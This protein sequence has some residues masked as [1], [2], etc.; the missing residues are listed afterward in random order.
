LKHLALLVV[1][2]VAVITIAILTIDGYISLD[3]SLILTVV[4]VTLGVL[5]L[6]VPNFID[7]FL[8][9][10]VTLQVENL[11]FVRKKYH[12]V[13]GY[14]LKGLIT[15]KGKR[16][17]LNLDGAFKIE[18]AQHRSP[19]LLYLRFDRE[20]G[21]ERVEAREEPMRAV[22]YAWI[23]EKDRIYRGMWKESRQK[24]CV[25]FVFP[26]ETVHIGVG[27]RSFWSEY[28]LKLENTKYQVAVEAKGED[29]EKNTVIISK[30]TKI[31][32]TY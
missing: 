24:D 19:N 32:P 26:Y 12:D 30:I 9:P 21:Q 10:R 28:L 17:C 27:S 16:I 1:I 14:Q 6:F 29:P 13:E 23:S 31:R 11:E 8:K 5:S 25:A 20:N 2:A 7:Y 15:N 4:T 18:D 3:T 22:G